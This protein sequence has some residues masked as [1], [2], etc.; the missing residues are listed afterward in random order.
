MTISLVGLIVIQLFWVSTAINLRETQFLKE[1]NQALQR[2]VEKLEK[3]EAMK[4]LQSHQAGRFL[5]FEND[6]VRGSWENLADTSFQY[7][8]M[9]DVQKS[10]D[11]IDIKITEEQNG[12]RFSKTITK[13]LSKGD[14]ITSQELYEPGLRFVPD[15]SGEG[16]AV[17]MKMRSRLANKTAFVG[18]IVK[19]LIQ[20][21]LFEKMDDRINKEMIDSLLNEEFL[22]VGITTGYDFGVFDFKEK[23][24]FS[25]QRNKDE[26][27]VN[28]NL[29]IRLFPN[30]IIDD[31][32]F[33]RVSFPRQKSYLLKTLWTMLL[34]SA[35]LIAIIIFVFSYTVIAI[36]RQK[37]I[38][39]IKN[40]FIN[41]MTH[42]LKTP[43]STI[44]LAC[45]ALKDEEMNRNKNLLKRYINMIEDE[46]K[47]L[48]NMVQNV[49]Q[50]AVWDKGEFELKKESLNINALI[51][52]VAEKTEI[53]VKEKQGRI[54]LDLNNDHSMVIA[55]KIHITNVLFNLL[56]N[57][58]KYTPENPQISISTMFNPP[59]RINAKG[60]IIIK[61]KDNGIGLRK[62]DQKRVFEKL[63]RVPTGNIHNVKGFGL[64]LN[65]VKTIVEKH[66]GTVGVESE[67]GKGSCFYVKIPVS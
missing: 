34:I 49:L 19:S 23:L 43:I 27:L 65:Y 40:D 66:N 67:F 56:D 8:V 11:K 18:D 1:V 61:I 55:D 3:E 36:I 5:F 48:G 57:A 13:N 2:V 20:V 62:E 24:I 35:L 31:A 26:N 46:N 45:E 22:N 64:G 53:Y 60:E 12:K 63:Y 30:D 25:R 58:I 21:N 47:R 14:T 16:K 42:E 4:K 59:S 33:L 50:S 29:Q 54:I 7:F 6:S 37:K 51:K 28:S 17:E 41:N 15:T 44:S 32:H 38:A 9:K 10:G 39:E 52:S